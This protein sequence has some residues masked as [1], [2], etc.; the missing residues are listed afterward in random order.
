MKRAA[1]LLAIA[2]AACATTPGQARPTARLGQVATVDGIRVRPL[3]VVEDSRCPVNAMCV[4]AGRLIV[5]TEVRAGGRRVIRNLE[6][7]KSQTIAGGTL[8]LS[9]VEPGKVAGVEADP[10]SYRFTFRFAR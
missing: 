9:S 7:G 2:L 4:W 8:T 1:L 5:R 6:L 3:S 10:R